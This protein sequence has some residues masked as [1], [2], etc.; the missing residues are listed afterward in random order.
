MS[1]YKVISSDSHVVEPPDLWINRIDSRFKERAPRL[2]GEEDGDWWYIDGKKTDS[3][4]ENIQADVRFTNPEALTTVGRFENVRAGAYI[5]D[6]FVK[7]L[8]IDGVL[9][10]VVYPSTFS[11]WG[12]ADSALLSAIFHTYNDWLAEFLRELPR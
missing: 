3:I 4:G 11:A 1:D 2:V 9:G 5:P 12:I 8:D 10:A 6:E 7:D